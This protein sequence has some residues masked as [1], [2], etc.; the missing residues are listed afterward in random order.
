[1]NLT[2]LINF[3]PF[4]NLALEEIERLMLPVSPETRSFERNEHILSAENAEEKI[5]FII[6]GECSVYK[7][8]EKQDILLQTLRANDSFGILTLFSNDE[9]PTLIIAKRQTKIVFFSKEDFLSLIRDHRIAFNV[10][11]FLSEK[12][13]F[14]NKKI[15]A[16][17]G[18]TVE[19]KV[20][21]HLQ[22]QYKTLGA[23]FPIN[24]AALASKLNIGRASLYRALHS[25]EENGLIELENKK[26]TIKNLAFLARF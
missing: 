15:A 23:T 25:M 9:Y 5:G 6:R 17:S 18:A 13:S 7:K 12:V 1:M 2:H 8:R 19:E 26:I 3:F 4:R 21:N 11:S 16:L 24:A 22:I 20:E 14:L 10:I